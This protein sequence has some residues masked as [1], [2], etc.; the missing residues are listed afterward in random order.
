MKQR[1]TCA[2]VTEFARLYGVRIERKKGGDNRSLYPSFSP[3][4]SASCCR[5]SR[6]ACCPGRTKRA[7]LEGLANM[8]NVEI[9]TKT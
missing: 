3:N 9:S 6:M 1:E 2:D 5:G 7:A 4:W 8:M